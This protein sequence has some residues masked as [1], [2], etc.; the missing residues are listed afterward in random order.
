M[1]TSVM[2]FFEERQRPAFLKN[3]YG[4]TNEVEILN[5]KTFIEASNQF[6]SEIELMV[7][8]NMDLYKD[9]YKIQNLLKKFEEIELELDERYKFKDITI[10]QNDHALVYIKAGNFQYLTWE[11][12]EHKAEELKK[13]TSRVIAETKECKKIQSLISEIR[14]RKRKVDQ[15][16]KELGV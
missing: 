9:K 5:D 1:I 8:E 11:S 4:K 10:E 13:T 6:L 7:N 15:R 3:I 2:S 16:L 14:E 12:D